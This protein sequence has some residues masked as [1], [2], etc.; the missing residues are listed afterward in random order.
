MG[1]LFWLLESICLLS[2][3]VEDDKNCQAF[4]T[5]ICNKFDHSCSC[6]N[7]N[8]CVPDCVFSEYKQKS[9]IYAPFPV[10]KPQLG[11]NRGGCSRQQ[12]TSNSKTCKSCRCS[13]IFIWNHQWFNFL[14]LIQRVVVCR[15]VHVVNFVETDHNW[16]LVLWILLNQVSR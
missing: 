5:L 8:G 12:D 1:R 4:W 2:K 10:L 15:N 7:R 16:V 9:H 13:L 3:H 14:D 6:R 11:K